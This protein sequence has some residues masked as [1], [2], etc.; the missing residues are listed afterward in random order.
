M[1]SVTVTLNENQYFPFYFYF[2]LT[3]ISLLTVGAFEVLRWNIITI[4]LCGVCLSRFLLIRRTWEF[5]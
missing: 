1:T 3:K 2:M 4:C 5:N